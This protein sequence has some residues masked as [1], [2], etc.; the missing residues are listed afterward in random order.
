M[1]YVNVIFSPMGGT[2]RRAQSTPHTVLF[3]YLLIHHPLPEYLT[4]PLE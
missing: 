1:R 4:S 3:Y 2:Q